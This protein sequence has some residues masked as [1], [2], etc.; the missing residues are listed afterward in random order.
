MSREIK[1]LEYLPLFLQQF[2]ELQTIMTAE[3]PEFQAVSDEGQVVLDNTFI[4]YCTENGIS[5]FEKLM[6]IYPLPDDTLETRRNRIMTRWNDT[7]PY[8]KNS[9][10]Q[11]I[12]AL[13]G[14]DNVQITL[15]NY[16]VNV[17]THLEKQGQQD[18]LAYLFKTVIPCN[19]LVVS[20]NILDCVTSG[21]LNSAIGITNA[22][23]QFIT[24]DINE[25]LSISTNSVIGNSYSN[26]EIISIKS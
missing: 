5:R 16:T 13:Q 9:F 24:N 19:M 25:H 11:K 22:G 26:T 2:Q 12:I 23:I 20:T 10:L 18:D 6:D 8:T 1:L 7:V 4:M 14:N 17:V 3:N 21:T 15:D